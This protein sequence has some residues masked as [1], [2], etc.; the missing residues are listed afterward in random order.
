MEDSTNDLF[1][2]NSNLELDKD[3]KKAASAPLE[4]TLVVARAGSGK[5]RVLIA[6][7]I[8]LQKIAGIHPSEI[9]M[10]AF[11]NKIKIIK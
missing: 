2:E 7:A 10:L 3:Q 6:R 5:T 1:G 4:N 11:N 9:L 8:Y